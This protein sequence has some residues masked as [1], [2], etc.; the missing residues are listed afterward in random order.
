MSSIKWINLKI[1]SYSK[2]QE[3]SLNIKEVYRTL[4]EEVKR[5]N[6]RNAIEEIIQLKEN[7]MKRI[8]ELETFIQEYRYDA[9]VS[10]F[11]KS[12][13]ILLNIIQ[14]NS[15]SNIRQKESNNKI[16]AVSSERPRN[17]SLKN[18]GDSF[19]EK[20]INTNVNKL[21]KDYSKN[22]AKISAKFKYSSKYRKSCEPVRRLK[23]S[24]DTKTRD[25]GNDI[26]IQIDNLDN[27]KSYQKDQ[28]EVNKWKEIVFRIKLNPEE[29]QLLK[30][31]KMIRKNKP[32][33]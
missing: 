20:D 17:T 33:N 26:N 3:E 4:V 1:Y 8:S 19:T 25:L 10:Y 14:A 9:R 5:S 32:I 12:K 29:Y 2:L 30:H 6:N 7:I 18:H 23:S 24:Q 21:I 15:R 22:Q 28:F 16:R 11:E 13:Q 31:E 27:S